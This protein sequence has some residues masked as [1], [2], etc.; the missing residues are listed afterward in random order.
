VL[1]GLTQLRGFQEASGELEKLVGGRD[2]DAEED[3]EEGLEFAR[4]ARDR[5]G[6][7]C[8]TCGTDRGRP[9]TGSVLVPVGRAT[10]AA[11][12][13]RNVWLG[14]RRWLDSRPEM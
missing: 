11:Q 4:G 9:G 6:R 3:L 2:S 10:A 1:D 13:D 7:T 8:K 5:T 14:V 12:V